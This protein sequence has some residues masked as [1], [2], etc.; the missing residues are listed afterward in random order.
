MRYVYLHGFASSPASVKAAFFRERFAELGITLEVPDLNQPV[1]RELTLTRI[2]ATVAGLVRRG[3]QAVIVGSSLGGYAAAL[4]ASRHPDRAAAL[5]LMAP[6][7]NMATLLR[8]RHGDEAM[9]RWKREGSAGVEHPAFEGPEPLDWSFQEDAE[10]WARQ[11]LRV[12]CPTLIL[13]GR[14]DP[15]VPVS[16]SERFAEAH[17][18]ARLVVLDSDHGLLDVLPDLWDASRGFLAPWMRPAA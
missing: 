14:H 17:P 1:F 10:Q 4:F 12:R 2:V 18:Q 5:V 6:A 13:H 15:E 8:E 16:G 11:D 9:E 3:E 7:F